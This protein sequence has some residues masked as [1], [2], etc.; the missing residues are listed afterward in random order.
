MS[1][2]TIISQ[3]EEEISSVEKYEFA[4]RNIE[5]WN[6]KIKGLRKALEIIKG[7]NVKHD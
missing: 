1:I 4:D 7:D 6:G 5:Y 2:D 3:I